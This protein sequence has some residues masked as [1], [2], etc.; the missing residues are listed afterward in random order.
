ML[1][2]HFF[3]TTFCFRLL[4]LQFLTR[5]IHLII[6]GISPFLFIV[7]F[8]L[9][10][11]FKSFSF[12][13]LFGFCFSPS[14]ALTTLLIIFISFYFSQ[15]AQSSFLVLQIILSSVSLKLCDFCIPIFLFPIP[16]H[17]FSPLHLLLAAV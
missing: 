10:H 15:H 11:P 12:T 2:F 5:D 17:D 16:F 3:I 14:S 8:N 13:P 9:L 4:R 7:L 6:V 1:P